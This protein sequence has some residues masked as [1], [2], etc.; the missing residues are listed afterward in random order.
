MYECSGADDPCAKLGE[1]LVAEGAQRR[2]LLVDRRD[3]AAHTGVGRSSPRR[4]AI[5]MRPLTVASSRHTPSTQSPA[6]SCASDP[7]V[8]RQPSLSSP[9]RFSAGT[10]TSVK[11]TSAK[12]AAPLMCRSGRTSMPGVSMSTMSRLMPLC[13]GASGSVR[14][15]TKHFCATIA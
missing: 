12:L 1:A 6:R 3:V 10:S 14:T 5:S 15:Y 4:C 7:C 2:G 8:M 9:T 13:F 11:N